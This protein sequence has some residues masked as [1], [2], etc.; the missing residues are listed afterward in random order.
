MLWATAQEA[1][2][3]VLLTEYFQDRA[4]IEGVS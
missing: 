2:A 1:G 3:T 4:L